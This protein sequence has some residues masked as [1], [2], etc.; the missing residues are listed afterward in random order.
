MKKHVLAVIA[1]LVFAVS[2]N[3][4]EDSPFTIEFEQLAPGVWSGL[5]PDP[6]R[7]PV[8]GNTVFVIGDE[9]VVVFDGGGAPAMSD[10]VIEKIRSLTEQPVSDVVIS[11]WHGDHAFGIHRFAEEYPGVRIIGHEFTRDMMISS[12]MNYLDGQ[13]DFQ[14][15]VVPLLEKFIEDGKTSAGRELN[16]HDIAFFRQIIADG[17]YIEIEG[18][19]SRVTPP[20]TVFTDSM[21]LD[22]GGRTI[23]LLHLGHGNTEGDIVMWLPEERIVATGDIVVHPAPYA[24]NMPP[25]PWAN[26]L[27]AIKALDYEFLVPGHGEVQRDTE[28]VDLLIE[29]AE[30]IAAQR[31]ALIEDGMPVE[32]GRRG[33]RLY[34][35]RAS[36]YWRRSLHQGALRLL[37]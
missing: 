20:D 19:R 22:P 6:I 36:L 37:F 4:K 27:K 14:N 29:S 26:T 30:D 34:A 13:S 21:S 24:F 2:A 1:A 17:E 35:S 9:S 18:K 23:E 3:A 25:I 28:Y 32:E 7:S 33:A 11:H 31:D 10:L 12:R 8:M 15:D 5:R 16:E